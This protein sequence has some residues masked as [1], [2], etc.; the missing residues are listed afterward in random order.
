MGCGGCGVATAMGWPARMT[1]RQGVHVPLCVG[2]AP[3]DGAVGDPWK[4]DLL[5]RLGG[6]DGR[7]EPNFATGVALRTKFRLYAETDP[8]GAGTGEAWGYLGADLELFRAWVGDRWAPRSRAA[9][10]SG[11][12]R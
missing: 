4:D 12:T 11:F 3:V 8:G 10:W 6:G 1:T 7:V 9:V 2:C 5:T